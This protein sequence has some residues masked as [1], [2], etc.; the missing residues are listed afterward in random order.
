M[1]ARIEDYALLG[2]CETAALVS[3]SGS[4]DWLCWPRF[5]SGAC[6]AALLGGPQHGCW[7]LAPQDPAASIK[8]RYR[9]DTLILET[10]FTTAAGA[11]TVIDFMPIRDRGSHVIRIVRGRSGRVRMRSQLI[12]RFDYGELVPWATRLEDGRRSFV[13]GP[14]RVLLST[15]V[16]L[17][18]E[19][20]TT[21]AD[22]RVA[23]G[24]N[25]SF[26]L[27]YTNACEALPRR[28]GPVA[29]LRATER[30]WRAW[31]GQSSEAGEY[32]E[33]VRR[34][35]ITLKALTYRP[36]GGILAAPTTSLPE[37]IGGERN[38]DYRYCWLRDATFALQAM[39]NTAHYAEAEA[40]R[41]WLLRAAAGDPDKLQILYSVIGERLQPE[42]QLSWLPGYE[43]S[44][45]V[46]IGN[47]AAEQVQLDVFGELME[48]LHQ[49][50]C[51]R[52][53]G[54]EAGWA[55]QLA[56]LGHLQRIWRKPDRGIWE[57]RGAPRHFT[58]SKIMAWVAF[59]RAIRSAEQFRLEAPLGRWRRLRQRMHREIC[60]RGFNRR[61]GAFVRSYGSHDVDA[62]T[63][64]L[65]L[66]GFL[67][68]TDPRVRG[69][70]EAIER[71]LLRG[72][73]VRRYDSRA[74]DGL[75]G[76]EG[77]FLACSFWLADNYVLLGRRDDARRLFE[78]LLA[79][80]ND[81]GL[82]SEEYDS[83]NR[84]FLGNFPQSLSHIA[85]VNTA[86]NLMR[87]TGPA[88]QRAQNRAHVR[89]GRTRTRV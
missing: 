29:A 88:R 17:R 82:L 84:R 85:L 65:P 38:W 28:I 40:W 47:A 63:L 62:S 16:A 3:R 76:G 64:L 31:V 19:D 68:A 48:V 9:P 81:V 89:R 12:L 11:V 26:V 33:A 4:I 56:L 13:A 27:S 58:H 86:L 57:I 5:D 24:E 80:R 52:L 18:G 46:R 10:E 54:G 78:R 36:S 50:R 30:F 51:S 83:A 73:L 66:V 37:R 49:A 69:T 20:L 44:A 1:P 23:A 61:I 42:W 39:M 6:C 32:G 70:V 2:D 45:P 67:P 15:P 79:L 87:R 60:R 55:L 21:V 75:R 77:A 8:R 25:V 34:S 53:A 35:L 72:G 74:G 71:R 59:D 14:H 7:A 43:K 41:S 22:F